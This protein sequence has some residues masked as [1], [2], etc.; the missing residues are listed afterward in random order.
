MAMAAV[1]RKLTFK[2]VRA[3]D[4]MFYSGS[5]NGVIDHVDLYLGYGWALD[6]SNGIG[7]VTVMHVDNGWYRDHFVHARRIVTAAS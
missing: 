5:G 4:L 6:S 7:G 3:G 2:Q 1:G